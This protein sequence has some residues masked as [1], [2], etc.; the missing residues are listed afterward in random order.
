MRLEGMAATGGKRD[1]AHS[2]G[3]SATR[4]LS[5][6]LRL[7]VTTFGLIVLAGLI[8][9]GCGAGATTAATAASKSRLDAEIGR[10]TR[11]GLLFCDAHTC[12]TGAKQ[13]DSTNTTAAARYDTLYKQLLGIETANI[14]TIKKTTTSDLDA[15]A[16]QINEKRAQGFV[17]VTL[18]QQRLAPDPWR[19]PERDHRQ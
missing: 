17:N 13:I 19:S 6:R 15:L 4:T 1:M 9:N 14:D 16:A 2:I 3:K 18:Y 7:A 12:T 5:R 11:L 10:A 8:L